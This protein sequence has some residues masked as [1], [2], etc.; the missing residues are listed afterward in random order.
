MCIRDRV[1]TYTV[2]LITDGP[3]G[4]FMNLLAHSTGVILNSDAI[5]EHGTELGT[6]IDGTGPYKLADFEAGD[7]IYLEA[8]EDYRCV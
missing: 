6:Y 3:I 8:N 4:N 1:D 5:K 2:K 7:H